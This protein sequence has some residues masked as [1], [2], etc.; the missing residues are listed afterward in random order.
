MSS[1]LNK[2]RPANKQGME[3]VRIHL[4]KE[5]HDALKKLATDS[6]R[7]LKHMTEFIVLEY[8]EK[9]GKA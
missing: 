6:R 3:S 4:T 5:H 1:T 8:L 7:K 2:D 9:G